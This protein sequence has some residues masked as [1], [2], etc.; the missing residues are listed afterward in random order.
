MGSPADVK[1][2]LKVF[3][4]EGVDLLETLKKEPNLAGKDGKTVFLLNMYCVF[5]FQMDECMLSS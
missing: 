3:R 1:G 2:R 5:F 4:L